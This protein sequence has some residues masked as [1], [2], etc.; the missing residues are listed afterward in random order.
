MPV[1]L[2]T[3][4]FVSVLYRYLSMLPTLSMLTAELLDFIGAACL[5]PQS[6]AS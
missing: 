2:R 1:M 5:L 4:L 6:V 3:L